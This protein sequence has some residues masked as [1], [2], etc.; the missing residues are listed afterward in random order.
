MSKPYDGDILETALNS[1][2]KFSAQKYNVSVGH[3][4]GLVANFDITTASQCQCEEDRIRTGV[5]WMC[6]FCTGGS[7]QRLRRY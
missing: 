6:M 1:G 7:N 5:A 4:R 2:L 3:V